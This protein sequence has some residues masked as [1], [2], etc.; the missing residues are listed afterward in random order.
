[1][2]VN[3]LIKSG[4]PVYEIESE[5]QISGRRR[6]KVVLHEIFS[7]PSQYQTNGISWNERYTSENMQSVVGMSIVAEFLGDER[8]EPYGHGMTGIKDNIPLFENATVVGHFEKVYIDNAL[9][10]GEQ[11]R[12][13]MAEGLLDEMRYP[14]FVQWI[15]EQQETSA[16]KGSVEIVGKSQND[17]YI[18]YDGGWKEKGR[19]PQVYD[20]SGYAILSITPADESA[21]VMELNNRRDASKKE[22]KHMDEKAIAELTV[23]LQQA[24]T[25]AC[26]SNADF[27]AQIAELNSKIETL[28]AEAEQKDNQISELNAQIAAHDAAIAEKDASIAEANAELKKLR[29]ARAIDELNAAL[30]PYTEEQRK[31]AEKEIEAF[32][33]EPGSVEINAIVG[34]I[35]TEIVREAKQVAEQNSAKIDIFGIFE[36]ADKKDPDADG[37]DDGEVNVF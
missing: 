8:D 30:A 14:K 20:Y 2:C 19:V 17:G 24:V 1:M 27:E 25:E 16:V 15:K 29:D 6:I 10:E 28:T 34:I 9:I 21:V 37:D 31:A 4:L 32:N 33:A 36:G 11:K 26:Q 23:T 12:V 13:L 5:A 22:D 3:D 7:D 35:C 18:I